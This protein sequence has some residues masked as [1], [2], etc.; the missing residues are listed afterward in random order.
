MT[1][2]VYILECINGAFYTGYTTDIDRRYKEH[3]Q[4]SLK[5]RYTRAFPPRRLAA[6]WYF[7]TKSDALSVES[8]I[9]KKSRQEKLQ[10]IQEWRATVDGDKPE[11]YCM[12]Q[13]H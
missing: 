11:S 2:T 12:T 3:Q 13:D 8:L 1:H 9:K 10:L 5:C 7:E 4:G 6:Y